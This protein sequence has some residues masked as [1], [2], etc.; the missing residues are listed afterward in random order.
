MQSCTS[1]EVAPVTYD[2]DHTTR[3]EY[4]DSVSVS[5][6]VARLRTRVL[7]HQDCL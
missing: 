2:V 5:H 3:Y 1:V 7:A 4:S 6:H